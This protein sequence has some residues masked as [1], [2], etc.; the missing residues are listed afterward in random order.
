MRVKAKEKIYYARR[1]YQAGEE[2][3]M[4]DRESVDINILCVTGKIE[5]VQTDTPKPTQAPKYETRT[6]QPEPP[7]AEPEQKPPQVMGTENTPLTRR[8]YRRRDMQADDKS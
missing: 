8:Y 1:E 4:D 6:V 5:K 2:F 7:A 3:D